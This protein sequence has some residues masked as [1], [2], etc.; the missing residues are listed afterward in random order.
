MATPI[1]V[2]DSPN[3]SVTT[4]VT[5]I[6]QSGSSGVGQNDIDY[7]LSAKESVVGSLITGSTISR[8][9]F[10]KGWKLPPVG[11][12]T[13]DQTSVSDFQFYLNGQLIDRT[14]IVGFDDNSAALGSVQGTQTTLS[15]QMG[16]PLRDYDVVTA[17]GKFEI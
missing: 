16:F 12:I 5:N 14:Q 6:S 11:T 17:L 9:V 2:L 10:D 13:Y 1:T 4:N 7:L 3:V 15:V 8:V